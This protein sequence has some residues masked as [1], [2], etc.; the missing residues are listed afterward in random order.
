ML[1]GITSSQRKS[2]SAIYDIM[3]R[4]GMLLQQCRGPSH[5]AY[6]CTTTRKIFTLK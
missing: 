1:R 4:V 6:L 5:L 3:E 2:R